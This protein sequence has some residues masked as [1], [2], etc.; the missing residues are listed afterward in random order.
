[1]YWS[2]KYSLFNRCKRPTP[3]NN[4][5][6]TT[7]YQL[8]YLGPIFYTLGSFCWSNFFKKDFIGIAPN[9]VAAVVSV[10]ILLIPYKKLVE[11]FI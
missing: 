2:Q 11:I 1:M 5:I 7:M 6:N 8:I 4:H 9:L 10:I 3:G